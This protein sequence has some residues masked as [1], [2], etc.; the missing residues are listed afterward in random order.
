MICILRCDLS[1]FA[2]TGDYT[3]TV[4]NDT[5]NFVTS[6]NASVKG[7]NGLP[8]D[9]SIQW[10]LQ[11]G[12]KLSL[13]LTALLLE[14]EKTKSP[15]GYFRQAPDPTKDFPVLGLPFWGKYYTAIDYMT[16][17]VHYVPQPGSKF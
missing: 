12:G 13:N 7:L 3:I 4:T 6:Y 1:C 9:L 10:P 8:G 5:F 15:S 14:E 16:G 2:D 11:E 17:L